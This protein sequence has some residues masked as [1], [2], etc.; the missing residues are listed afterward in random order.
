MKKTLYLI[1]KTEN[2]N[3]KNKNV[4]FFCDIIPGY[5]SCFNDAKIL[6]EIG[7]KNIKKYSDFVYSKLELFNEKKLIFEEDLSLYSLSTFS[8]KRSEVYDTYDFCINLLFIR[9]IVRKNGFNEIVCVG[10]DENKKFSI[11]SFFK[12]IDLIFLMTKTNKLKIPLVLSHISFYFFAFIKLLIISFFNFKTNK[13][14]NRLFFF[15][16]PITL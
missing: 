4:Y 3:I 9:N 16:I 12:S 5:K 8:N 15:K 7:L 6:N 13:L 2:F 11:E 14:F 1:N 10:F